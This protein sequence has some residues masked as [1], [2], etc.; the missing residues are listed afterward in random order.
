MNKEAKDLIKIA[1]E[2]FK[3]GDYKS[4]LTNF[5]ELAQKLE[6]QDCTIYHNIALTYSK[7]DE[8]DLA[9][10]NFKK[11]VEIDEKNYKAL[12]SLG[13]LYT[14]KNWFKEALTYLNKSLLLKPQLCC[15][16]LLY[17]KLQAQNSRLRFGA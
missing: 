1:S 10:K 6:P 13:D 3:K 9:I 5:L 11:I 17:G 15:N 2:Y 14:Q 4:A 7:M 16:S 12:A 8:K